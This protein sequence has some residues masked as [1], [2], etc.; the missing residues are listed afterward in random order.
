MSLYHYEFPV[1]PQ[2][3]V[4]TEFTR[5]GNCKDMNPQ[6]FY[7]ERGDTRRLREAKSVCAGCVVK[8]ECLEY[9]LTPPVEKWGIWGGTSER[10]RRQMRSFLEIRDQSTSR[11]TRRTA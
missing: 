7:P 5:E 9:A 8:D 11:I 6:L 1:P 2:K 10:E 4:G 3:A